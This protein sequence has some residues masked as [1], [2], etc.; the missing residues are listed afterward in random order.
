M[1]GFRLGTFELFRLDCGSF[2]LD[3]GYVGHPSSQSR[4]SQL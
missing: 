4:C 2:E 1:R 3:D